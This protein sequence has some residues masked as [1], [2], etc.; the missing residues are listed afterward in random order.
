MTRGRK[1]VW[2]IAVLLVCSAGPAGPREAAAGEPSAATPK[3]EP[4]VSRA[5]P[6][7]GEPTPPWTEFR[8][9]VGGYAVRF[10][11]QAATNF[12]QLAHAARAVHGQSLFTVMYRDSSP[13]VLAAVGADQLL[14]AAGGTMDRVVKEQKITFGGHPG[15]AR[16]SEITLGDRTAYQ[17]SRRYM[18][19]LRCYQLVVL[20]PAGPVDEADA[21]KF[22]DSFRLVEA[23]ECRY[24]SAHG[25]YSV[26]FP[27][28]PHLASEQLPTPA[29]VLQM[30]NAGLTHGDT[31]Y[32]VGHC[33][34]PRVKGMTND[35]LL[36][37]VLRNWLRR[38]GRVVR[39]EAIELDGHT[40]RTVLLSIRIGSTN[41]LVAARIYIVND[42]LYQNMVIGPARSM[43]LQAAAAFLDSFKL[44]KK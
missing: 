27:N 3:G 16:W 38:Q 6:A 41:G 44:T 11:T 4:V 12:D 31:Y 32:G 33:D 13:K 36:D 5:D 28:P 20:N 1:L 43:D 19:N 25:S 39:Q 40:G 29:G 8:S 21:K 23:E 37:T 7:V 9:A 2:L 35:V 15:R 10:P 30:R 14:D 18:V 17:V 24:T 26:L 42:R 34:F 22:F